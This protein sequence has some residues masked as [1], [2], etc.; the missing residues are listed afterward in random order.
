MSIWFKS[1]DRHKQERTDE[2]DR[3]N[4]K[5]G[6]RVSHSRPLNPCPD[7]RALYLLGNRVGS[8]RMVHL[9]TLGQ[10]RS[11]SIVAANLPQS[12][13]ARLT[14][15]DSSAESLSSACWFRF[16]S[17][18]MSPASRIKPA[19]SAAAILAK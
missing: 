16:L 3:Q 17:S 2:A 5:T 1:L 13:D 18:P 4:I 6:L 8:A 12:A 9:Q 15:Q 19:F 14:P 11:G 10:C 7:L